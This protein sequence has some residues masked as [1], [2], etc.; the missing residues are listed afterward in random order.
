MSAQAQAPLLATKL[1]APDPRDRIGRERLI[2]RLSDAHGG[3]LALI[4]APAGWG[5]STL[6]SQWRSED[7]GRRGFAWVTLDSSD[8]DPGR[9][10][11][12]ALEAPRSGGPE[13]GSRSRAITCW[14]G[15]RFPP[16]SVGC[17][18]TSVITCASR[19][20]RGPNRTFRFPGS[21]PA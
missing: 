17:W 7:Q 6:L 1:N 4:R 12:Y 11:A 15:T 8:S 18:T 10:W 2:G 16:A 13:V 20:R 3:R 14:R 9:F 21:A 19:S 5:K